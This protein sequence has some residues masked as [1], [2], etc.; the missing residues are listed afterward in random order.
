MYKCSFCDKEYTSINTL[1]AHLKV[2]HNTL[3][4]TFVCKQSNC[5]RSFTNI[6]PFKRHLLLKHPVNNNRFST[7]L[8]S[9]HSDVPCPQ[10][11]HQDI[12]DNYID[13]Q[14]VL[15]VQD[16]ENVINNS[17]ITFEQFDNLVTKYATLLVSKLYSNNVLP[18]SLAH[19]II[20]YVSNVYGV[21]IEI[22]KRKY[23]CEEL[24]RN[25]SFN[26]KDMYTVLQ[27][28]FVNFKTEHQTLQFL[29]RRGYLIMPQSVDIGARFHPKRIKA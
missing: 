16:C 18:R 20:E 5:T 10:I 11:I 23:E 17:S 4:S 1:I 27:N 8:H 29:V 3:S 2:I 14:H 25:V 7:D 19:K 21:T 13:S 22:I 26:I 24:K 6:H 15:T 9:F 12:F 28:A